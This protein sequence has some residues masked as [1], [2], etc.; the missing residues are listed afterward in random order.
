[1]E[2]P[3]ALTHSITNNNCVPFIGSGFSRNG[4]CENGYKIPLW[5]DLIRELCDILKVDFKTLDKN[6]EIYLK[7]AQ[8]YQKDFGRIELIKFLLDQVGSSSLKP[9]YVHELLTQYNFKTI[10][11]TNFDSLI[12]DAYFKQNKD[13]KIIANQDQLQLYEENNKYIKIVKMHGDFQNA[14]KIVFTK[15][16]YDNYFSNNTFI[17]DYLKQVFRTKNILLLG[18]SQ[19]DPDYQQLLKYREMLR[20]F[21]QRIF[22]V[23]LDFDSTVDANEF[24]DKSNIQ[25]I[26]LGCKELSPEKLII[27]FLH[28]LYGSYT[29]IGINEYAEKLV[30]PAY[31]KMNKP[32]SEDNIKEL[33]NEICSKIPNSFKEFLRKSNGGEFVEGVFINNIEEI[34][35][36]CKANIIDKRYIE[37]F[38]NYLSTDYY[39]IYCLDVLSY[40]QDDECSVV[41]IE[42]MDNNKSIVDNYKNFSEFFIDQCGYWGKISDK[43]KLHK[44]I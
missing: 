15:Q 3:K 23:N 28:E 42:Y 22:V 32:A 37:I 10:I 14:G 38:R 5:E 1:M 27:R 39:H 11:T 44:K 24:D 16:D 25:T 18:Y 12:E 9:G 4:I 35:D 7:I 8:Q 13:A 20:D 6:A 29:N 31:F 33:E 40:Y 36:Q 41:K 21:S 30:L 19:I 34:I 17:A 43:I 2:I 26:S